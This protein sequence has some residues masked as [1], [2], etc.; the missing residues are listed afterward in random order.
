MKKALL[1]LVIGLFA[2]N[3]NSQT[4]NGFKLEEI[5]AKYIEVVS[6]AKI[7]KIF[8]VTVYLDYGQ[9][10]KVMEMKIGKVLGADGKPM[11]FNGTMGVLNLLEQKGFKYLNQ[12]LITSG[13]Q[14]VYHTILE[15]TNYKK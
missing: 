9:I 8:Q 13:S 10:S 14:L 11:A 7:F 2:M 12:Y 4:V 6:T 1:V 15:N 3:M 5:P